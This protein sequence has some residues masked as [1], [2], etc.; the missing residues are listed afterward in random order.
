MLFCLHV[1]L[2]DGSKESVTS[3]MIFDLSAWQVIVLKCVFIRSC[4]LLEE[5]CFLA[6]FVRLQYFSESFDL[7]TKFI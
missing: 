2:E 3:V 4:R 6:C 7:S 5:E 1:V